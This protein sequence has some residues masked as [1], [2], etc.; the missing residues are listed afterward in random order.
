MPLSPILRWRHARARSKPVQ[1]A[2]PTA[3]RNIINSCA[4]KKSWGTA[5]SSP[6]ERLFIN[7][8]RPK[9]TAGPDNLGRLGILAGDRSQCHRR[10]PETG[11]RFAASRL[12]E[13]A[14]AYIGAFCGIAG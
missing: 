11:L 10:R 14:G 4:S 9:E 1:P 12:P 8:A 3:S 2:A 5:R 7:N 13:H 6:D